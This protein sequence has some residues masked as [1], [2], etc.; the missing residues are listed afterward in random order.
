[1]TGH[2]VNQSSLSTKRSVT[3]GILRDDFGLTLP[4]MRDKKARREYMR[5]FKR[6][7]NGRRRKQAMLDWNDPVARSKYMAT[8]M[9]L[10]RERRR[11]NQGKPLGFGNWERRV[12]EPY[13][14]RKARFANQ[15]KAG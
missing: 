5:T 10:Y 3:R 4:D 1:M 6:I 12:F 7:F 15:D 8:Y 13:E 9:R 14:Q 2:V 11:A